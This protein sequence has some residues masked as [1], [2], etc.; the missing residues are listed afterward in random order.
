MAGICICGREIDGMKE[1]CD[2]CKCN[3]DIVDEDTGICEKC[4]AYIPSKRKTFNL[5]YEKPKDSERIEWI[6]DEYG[7]RHP[8]NTDPKKVFLL[9]KEIEQLKY[10]REILRKHVRK[11]FEEN[12]DEIKKILEKAR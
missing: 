10:E 4:T 2:V 3:H 11:Y 7:C 8:I 12:A 1:Y 5:S 6:S 9:N